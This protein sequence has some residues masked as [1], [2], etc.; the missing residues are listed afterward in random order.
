MLHH[1]FPILHFSGINLNYCVLNLLNLWFAI[2][3]WVP[4]LIALSYRNFHFPDL[5]SHIV[6]ISSYHLLRLAICDK[7]SGPTG[8]PC[9]CHIVC[10]VTCHVVFHISCH[11]IKMYLQFLGL[12]PC[13][14][15]RHL[16]HQLPHHLSHSESLR[17]SQ[18]LWFH[19]PRKKP[20]RTLHLSQ[21]TAKTLP[22]VAPFNI[23]RNGSP[24]LMWY[25]S[26]S[27]LK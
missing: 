13:H 25:C 10:H 8:V 2:S 26:T 24:Y 7:V 27:Q 20:Y 22:N 16:P 12:G 15:P 4:L 18:Y 1:V 11:V 19:N 14:L 6:S 21:P 9:H 3:D 23:Y 17:I 5:L